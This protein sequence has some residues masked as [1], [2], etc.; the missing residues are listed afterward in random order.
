MLSFDLIANDIINSDKFQSLKD[1]PHHGITR[2]EHV[3]R[4]AKLTYKVS[5]HMDVDYVSATRGALLHDYFN[6]S[7]YHNTHGLKK[8]AMH[9]VIALNNARRE[10]KLNSKEENIIASHMY[11]LGNVK[12]NCKESWIVTCADKSVAIYECGT[13]KF[14]EQVALWI[15]FIINIIRIS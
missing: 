12:P 1:D 4:V 6:D 9:P 11:P 15:L 8:G 2:Y 3:M 14:K 10:Y 13:Y 7:D 5:K